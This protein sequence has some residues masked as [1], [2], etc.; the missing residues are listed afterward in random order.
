MQNS[1]IE[2]GLIEL[3]ELSRSHVE[4][5]MNLLTSNDSKLYTLDLLSVAVYRRSMSLIAGFSDMIRSNN[6]TCAVPL[7]RMQLDNALRFYAT[8]LVQNPDK[9]VAKFISGTHIG[10]FT[11]FETGRK[12]SDTYL[13]KHL[14]KKFPGI[15]QVYR[16]TSGF[17][18]LSEKHLFSTLGKKSNAERTISVTIG[19]DDSYISNFQR[20]DAVNA[21]IDITKIVLWVLSGWTTHKEGLNMKT[22][23]K[24]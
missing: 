7:I 12:L 2:S 9:F 11:D 24:I 18:H 14:G 3:E 15:I 21:M 19:S 6:F 5:G 16:D 17:I 20:E 22:N 1:K 13:V 23:K 4:R 10:D 8:T